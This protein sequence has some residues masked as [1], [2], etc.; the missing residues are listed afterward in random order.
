MEEN[1]KYSAKAKGEVFTKKIKEN[2][3]KND[4]KNGKTVWERLG[5]DREKSSVCHNLD[6]FKQHNFINCNVTLRK[7]VHEESIFHLL[8]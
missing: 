3:N 1:W 4:N 2:N 8:L 6:G 7:L 5:M